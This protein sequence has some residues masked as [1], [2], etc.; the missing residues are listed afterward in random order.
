[1]REAEI[2][3]YLVQNSRDPGCYFCLADFEAFMARSK[4][5]VLVRPCLRIFAGRDDS[6]RTQPARLFREVLRWEPDNVAAK[7]H[8]KEIGDTSAGDEGGLLRGLFRK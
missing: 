4:G 3:V 5:G 7:Q 8:I 1:M 6:S 2:A